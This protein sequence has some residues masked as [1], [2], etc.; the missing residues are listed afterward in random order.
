MKKE[1]KLKPQVQPQS[2]RLRIGLLVVSLIVGVVLA[3]VSIMTNPH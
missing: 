2:N 1:E 3:L